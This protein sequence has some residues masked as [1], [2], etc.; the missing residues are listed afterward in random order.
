MAKNFRCLICKNIPIAPVVQCTSCEQLYCG[1]QC[2]EVYKKAIE[3]QKAEKEEQAKLEK[4][5]EEAEAQKEGAEAENAAADA[6]KKE[7]EAEQKEDENVEKKEVEEAVKEGENAKKGRRKNKKGAVK[8]ALPDKLCCLNKKCK[9]G[10]FVTQ[11]LGRI[12]RNIMNTFEFE[13]DGGAMGY[14]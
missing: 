6:E 8:K 11:P 5:K 13:H 7:E 4:A 2:L 10:N 9:S 14:E 1:Q 12:I 3:K